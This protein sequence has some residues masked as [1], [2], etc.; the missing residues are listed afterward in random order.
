M[1]DPKDAAQ[2]LGPALSKVEGP[3]LS[4]VEGPALRKVEGV[5]AGTVSNKLGIH[6]V[7]PLA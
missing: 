3:A 2:G 1:V 7:S 6:P 4:K 5:R